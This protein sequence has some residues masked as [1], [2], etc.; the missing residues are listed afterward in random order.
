[1]QEREKSME[2]ICPKCQAGRLKKWE[3]LTPD[4]KFVVE[5]L[6]QSAD[7]TDEER[8]GHL[9]CPRCHYETKPLEEKI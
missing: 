4:E 8:K 2:K 1:M 7:Y 5:R 3:D 6:P 9:F